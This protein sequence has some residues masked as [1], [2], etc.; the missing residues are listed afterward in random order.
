MRA[1]SFWWRP[2]SLEGL[3][4]SPFGQLYGAIAGRRLGRPGARAARPVL[5]IGNLV[6]G[7]AGKTPVALSIVR[8]LAAA[9]R[10]P[11]VLTRGYGGILRTPTLVDLSRH[12]AAATGDEAQLLAR[13]APTVVAA[14]R[15]AGAALA[16]TLGDV[17]V[18]DDGLQNP[19]LAKDLSLVVVDG[20][21]GVGNGRCIPAGPLRAPLARQWPLVGAL[22]VVGPGEPGSALAEDARA[23]GL[24]VLGARLEPMDGARFAGRRVLAFAGIGRPQKFFD[25]LA[26]L[27]AEVVHARAFGDHQPYDRRVLARLAEEASARDLL[28]VTTA[29]D[30]ARLGGLAGPEGP[31]RVEVLEVEAR[32]DKPAALDALLLAAIR[33][34]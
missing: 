6:A 16:A 18:M 3:L 19:S 34:A 5:C 22:V 26:A 33:D 21:T 32:F 13:V 11:V 15:P 7:G 25:T 24:P 4:L 1:P 31:V 30:R 20:A 12:D 14:D 17:I 23:R 29:K 10:Q 8:Q 9:G 28:L 2:S 27:G